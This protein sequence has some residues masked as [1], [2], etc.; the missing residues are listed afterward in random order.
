MWVNLPQK[1]V[2]E[3]FPELVHLFKNR[4]DAH[5]GTASTIETDFICPCCKKEYKRKI[6]NVVRNKHVS[7]PTCNDGFSYP[8][9]FMAN[10]LTQLNISF[11]YHYSD[12]TW[13]QKYIY[14]FR[15]DY[16]GSKYIIETDGGLGHGH[17]NMSKIS[18][19][20]LLDID[21]IKDQLATD[22]GYHIIRIDCDYK[23]DRYQYIKQSIINALNSILDL[24]NI[25]WNECNI[26]SLDSMFLKVIN[27]YKKDSIFLDNI[28]ELT[29][30]KIRTIT[31][32]LNEAMKFGILEKQKLIK[33]NPYKD[34]P[35]GVKFV[36]YK[37]NYSGRSRK[38]YCFEDSIIFNSVTDA[39]DY[40]KF[41]RASLYQTLNDSI[42]HYYNKH[43]IYY[44]LLKKDFDFNSKHKF[45][46]TY[47]RKIYQYDKQ[48]NL[49]ACFDNVGFLRIQH[50]DY[51]YGHINQVCNGKRK[52]AYGFIWSYELLTK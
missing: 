33:N 52:S 9:K 35:D 51:D 7:C 2:D 41:N 24:S 5:N 37:D 49:I 25:D 21:R 3:E 27:C 6:V 29:G 46:D 15:F 14:D 43:F 4:E 30:I 28:S 42:C 34:I 38:L 17:R 40:Y 12:K 19:E 18:P 8:E 36:F 16:N 20:E 10:V 50:P 1:Y 11:D 32:Y 47:N 31:K 23:N 39:A 44:D 48:L 13:T 22:N 45:V 26:K